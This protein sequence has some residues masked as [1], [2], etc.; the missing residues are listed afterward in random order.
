MRRLFWADS[1]KAMLFLISYIIN[2]LKH[3]NANS[4]LHLE[5]A[6]RQDADEG[7]RQ[8]A[9]AV[10][11]KLELHLVLGNPEL[12]VLGLAL[13][14][15]LMRELVAHHVPAVHQPHA[16]REVLIDFR[17]GVSRELFVERHLLAFD[18][19]LGLELLDDEPGDFDSLHQVEDAAG[20]FYRVFLKFGS[21]LAQPDIDFREYVHIERRLCDYL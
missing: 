15:D 11:E 5:L 14:E 13:S 20:D 16:Q 10:S 21:L 4:A 6:A 8:C 17:L 9:F 3:S 1:L 7:L 19:S 2:R 18:D 12:R